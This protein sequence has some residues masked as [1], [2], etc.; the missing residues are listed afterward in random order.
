MPSWC[1][2]PF[3][4]IEGRA[5]LAWT[6]AAMI[7]SLLTPQTLRTFSEHVKLLVDKSAHKQ[8]SEIMTPNEAVTQAI[9]NH[10]FRHFAPATLHTPAYGLAVVAICWCGTPT[11]PFLSQESARDAHGRHQARLALMRSFGHWDV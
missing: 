10:E 4:L 6:L 2:R 9:E 3:L 1:A 5:V 8:Y 11:P 7:S